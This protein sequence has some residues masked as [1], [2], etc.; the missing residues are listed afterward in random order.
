VT[1]VNPFA[2]PTNGSSLTVGLWIIGLVAMINRERLEELEDWNRGWRD[3]I[4]PD[5]SS[6]YVPG[7]G[8]NARVMIIGEAPGAQEEIKRRPFVGA[9]GK[10]LRELMSFADLYTGGTPQ[11]GVANCWLTNV[12]K[13][14]PPGNRTPTP[15]EVMGVRHLLRKEW[16]AVGRPAIVVPV[17]AVALA[18]V[19]GFKRK[20]SILRVAG[21]PMLQLSQEGHTM[22]VWPM[23]HPSF[24]L[25]NKPVIPMIEKHWEEF[26]EWLAD[27]SLR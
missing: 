16:V 9:A 20:Y 5:L 21:N 6:V 25:R 2:V 15:T 14:R 26:G 24:G 12:V 13:F 23:I 19:K 11:L 10:V 17:G 18:A 1:T 3:L 7:E 22:V 27:D 8:D 4:A